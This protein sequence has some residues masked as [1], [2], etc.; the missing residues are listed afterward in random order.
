M[1]F[2]LCPRS[3]SAKVIMIIN[4]LCFLWHGGERIEDITR[5]TLVEGAYVEVCSMAAGQEVKRMKTA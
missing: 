1:V 4:G 2:L 5:M 3:L